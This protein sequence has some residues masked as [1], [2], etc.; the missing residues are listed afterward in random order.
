MDPL[1]DVNMLLRHPRGEPV[2]QISD[3]APERT[4]QQVSLRGSTYTLRR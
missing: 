3:H 2:T 1:E 4:G